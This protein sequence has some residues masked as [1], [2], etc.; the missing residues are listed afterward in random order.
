MLQ[1]KDFYDDQM[2]LRQVKRQAAQAAAEAEEE[3]EEIES[4]DDVVIPNTQR[5]VGQG[6][7]GSFGSDSKGV[8]SQTLKQESQGPDRGDEEGA[9]ESGEDEMEE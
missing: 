2:I 5:V 6:F 7:D 1:L 8:R 9:A 4:E 3:E